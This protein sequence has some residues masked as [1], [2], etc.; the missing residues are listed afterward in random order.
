MATVTR[1]NIGELN[2]KLIV[3][4]DKE[5]YLPSFE[6]SLKQYGKSANLPGFR[7]GM[8]P[9][10]LI[11][12][13]HGQSVFT[14][15]VLRAVENE[16]TRYMNDEKLEIFAQPL[17]LPE[18]D[19]GE[20]DVNRPAEYSFGFEI[21]LKPDFQVVDLSNETV[22]KY[23]V[24]VTDE[25]VDHQLDRLQK[26]YGKKK[27]PEGG[28]E[29]ENIEKAELNEDFFKLAYPGKEIHSEEELRTE[30][31]KDI[32]EYWETQ[33]ANQ[34]QHEIYHRLLDGSSIS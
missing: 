25:M 16:L 10:G 15:E 3:K 22:T 6:K 19:P 32:Q 20:L 24:D 29:D 28:D 30:I 33:S 7:K 11:K 23:T 17:P 27:D 26:A 5:D 2:D 21:G 12:K 4:V 18:N 9:A 31:R 1:E 8:V 13:M 34:L 14:E